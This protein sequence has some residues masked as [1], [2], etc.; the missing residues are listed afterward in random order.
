M[1]FQLF[2]AVDVRPAVDSAS[3][4]AVAPLIMLGKDKDLNLAVLL[5]C[6]WKGYL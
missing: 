4:L 6:V 1:K 3:N 5:D 2:W